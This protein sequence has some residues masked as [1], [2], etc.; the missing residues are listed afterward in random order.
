MFDGIKIHH[1]VI[2]LVI[3]LIALFLV[4]KFGGG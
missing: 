1:V 3:G 2:A 4:K